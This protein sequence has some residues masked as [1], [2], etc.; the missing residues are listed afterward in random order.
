MARLPYVIPYDP[1]FLGD[2]FSVPLPQPASSPEGATLAGLLLNGGQTFDY[3]H[4]SVVI[5]RTRRQSLLTACNIDGDALKDVPRTDWS[6]DRRVGAFQI[7]NEAYRDT[8]GRPNP[9]DRGHLVRRRD[10]CWGTRQ[11]AKDAN[12]STF[13][14]PN[15][16]LQHHDFNGDEWNFLEDWVLE[17]VSELAPRLCVLTGQ[18][19]T[20][21]DPEVEVNPGIRVQI[22]T[23]FWKVIVLRDPTDA[24]NDLTAVGFI[25]PQSEEF[26]RTVVGETAPW[27]KEQLR[28]Y[29]VPLA[30][31]ER[32][33]ALDF[34]DLRNVDDFPWTAVRFR[35]DAAWRGWKPIGEPDD[36][37]LGGSRRR[38]AGVR[39]L[40]RLT[41]TSSPTRTVL[42]AS[43]VPA[44][45]PEE[46]CGCGTTGD[47]NVRL[48]ILARQVELLADT[49]R[50]YG[51][52]KLAAADEQASVPADSP[53]RLA[54]PV[55]RM[56]EADR[57]RAQRLIRDAERI[58]G[59]TTADRGE[60]PSCVVL[61]DDTEFYC[62]GV[63]I[64]DRVVLTAGHCGRDIQRVLAGARS[65]REANAGHVQLRYVRTVIP[66][67]E[68]TE[69]Y[70]PWY[71]ISL[72]VL[73]DP[74][75]PS[76]TVQPVPLLPDAN[77]IDLDE[78]DIVGF[79]TTNA[80]GTAQFGRKRKA[81]VHI[82]P[83]DGLSAAE[84]RAEERRIGFGSTHEFFAG[85]ENL[86]ID[87]CKGDSGGPVYA[88][89]GDAVFLV[90]LTSRGADFADTV[91]GDGGIYT[92]VLRFADWIAQVRQEHGV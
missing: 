85:K 63:L 58:M 91:C 89:V 40:R 21:D 31:L 49:L 69:N 56:I 14:Y 3:I 57:T 46:P 1:A 59:G 12:S 25:I 50:A 79:G 90:G 42:A 41:P 15:S 66:H 45:A 32:Y 86:G 72:I 37:V 53:L 65:I 71:D 82:L 43:V 48:E 84:L 13:F 52:E 24:A 8:P 44:V 35:R 16:A 55:Q 87:T 2:G 9:W 60:F 75:V 6:L 70:L 7:G 78:L 23:A 67:A 62:T 83:T 11:R 88:R 73:A 33:T 20:P 26:I 74:I 81:V 61:G 22:P 54:A 17:K 36:I 64:S 30:D 68:F 4:Y 19:L 5:H 80:S 51:A 28:T 10:V 39:A 29:Q 38:A 47:T 92:N 27:T 76:E 34:G 77:F 18:F